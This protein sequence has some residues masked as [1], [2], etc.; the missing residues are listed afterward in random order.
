MCGC[1]DSI[2]STANP[3]AINLQ[4]ANATPSAREPR[5]MRTDLIACL[6]H[7]YMDMAAAEDGIRDVAAYRGN[8]RCL[9]PQTHRV[10]TQYPRRAR[11]APG[12]EFNTGADPLILN[13]TYVQGGDLLSKTLVRRARGVP[14]PRHSPVGADSEGTRRLLCAPRRTGRRPT[15]PTTTT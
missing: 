2:R 3:P 14:A 8:S 6:L 7:A 13:R 15:S 12:Y 10:R 5:L 4:L 9:T 11:I 1:A